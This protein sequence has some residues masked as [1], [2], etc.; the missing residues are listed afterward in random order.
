MLEFKKHKLYKIM[1]F[2]GSYIVFH[3]IIK[4]WIFLL[5]KLLQKLT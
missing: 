3:D 2:E 4:V 5:S 1:K